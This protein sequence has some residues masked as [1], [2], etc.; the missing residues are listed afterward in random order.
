[1]RL[2]RES[3]M[4]GEI[5]CLAEEL[6][7]RQKSNTV[8]TGDCGGNERIAADDFEAETAGALG[9]FKA[10]AAE[11]ENAEGLATQ[12]RALQT[13]L[14][15][16]AGVHRGVGRRQLAREGEHE[17]DGELR[18]SDGVGARGIH[19]DDTAARSSFS[20]DVVHAHPGAA[21]DAQLR[22]RR[23]QCVVNLHRGA[24]D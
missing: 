20:V 23:H 24:D 14:L 9:D 11:A 7:H 4:Q 6:V 5:V 2:R 22:C 21:N 18:D 16:L 15:P 13:L 3:Y 19:D 10:D 8:F 17:A 12:L 1:M